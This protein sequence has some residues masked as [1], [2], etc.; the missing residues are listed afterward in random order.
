MVVSMGAAGAMFVTK[1]ICEIVTPPAVE[2]KSMVGA[3]DSMVA[4]IVFYLSQ[5]KNIMEAVQYGVACGTA[6][7]MNPGTELCKKEDADKLYAVIQKA[8]KI[9]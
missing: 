9:D 7:T 4:G 1:D 5:S 2:R 8:V 3:G 6:A